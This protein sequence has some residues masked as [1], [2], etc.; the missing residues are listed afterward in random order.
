M[1]SKLKL[2]NQYR[3][4]LCQTSHPGNIGSVARAMK[5]MGIHDLHLVQPKHF[6]HPESVSLACGADDILDNAVRCDSLPEALTG[7]AFAI[8]LTARARQISHPLLPVREA[9]S[10]ATQIATQNQKVALV[11]GNE[12]SGLSNREL[13]VCNLLAMIP[14]NPDFSSLNI[15]AAVQVVCYEL[16]IAATGGD[17]S[18]QKKTSL[19]TSEE[20]EGF[21]G[22]L[23]ETL[24]KIGY[25]N[26]DSPKKLLLRIRRIYSRSRLEKEEVNIL[27]GILKLT[28]K[29]RMIKKG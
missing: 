8:G 10:E 21:F 14:T 7:C 16:F 22:H 28:Q 27:R 18:P 11:F 5:T 12:M 1:T 19:A 29:P 15:A 13:A 6:P 4:V 3:I 2:L 24:V 25:L 23:E 26:I 17:I 9:I 20:M